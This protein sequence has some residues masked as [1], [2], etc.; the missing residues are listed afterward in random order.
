MKEYHVTH[1]AYGDGV[2]K[3]IEKGFATVSFANGEKKFLLKGFDSFFKY[4]DSEFAAII[5]E[6]N[7][8]V[9]APTPASSPTPVSKPAKQSTLA[10][11]PHTNEISNVL[12]GPRSQTIPIY[13]EHQMFEIVG[14]LAAPGRIKTIEAEVPVDG[15]D[16]VFE[17]LFPGQIY[18]PIQMADTPSGMPNKLSPQFRINLANIRNCPDILKKNMGAGN[19]RCVARINKSLFVITMVQHYGFRFGDKQDFAAIKAIAENKG[20]LADFEKGLMM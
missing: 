2:V 6:A 20:F 18:R 3:E 13:N 15:R 8:P 19:A 12:L 17:K 7:R 4:E 10:Y 5:S 1:K 11:S 16:K 9:P 14:Y